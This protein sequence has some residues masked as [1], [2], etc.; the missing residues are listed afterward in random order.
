MSD[1]LCIGRLF[2]YKVDFSFLMCSVGSVQS[3][4]RHDIYLRREVFLIKYLIYC[5]LFYDT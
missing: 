5:I 1:A 4:S 3:F 2:G